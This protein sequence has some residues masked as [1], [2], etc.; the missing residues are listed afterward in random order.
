MGE[1]GGR[2][3]LFL[4]VEYRRFF[5][6]GA[7]FNAQDTWLLFF[8]LTGVGFSLV[9]VTTL[10]GRVW[11][12]WACPQTVFLEGMFRPLERILEGT[13]EARMRRD[14]RPLDA[15]QDLART[16]KHTPSSSRRCSL[17]HVFVAYFVSLPRSSR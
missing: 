3:A 5:L 16:A 8:L 11:C 15:R 4:D 12:G 1:I 9:L 10:L 17:A 2:P 7:T 14:R 13:R 6:F